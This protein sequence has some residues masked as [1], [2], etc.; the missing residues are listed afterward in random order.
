MI[1]LPEILRGLAALPFDAQSEATGIANLAFP[2][3]AQRL[4]EVDTTI[5]D[6]AR[7]LALKARWI[8]IADAL[9]EMHD[10]RAEMIEDGEWR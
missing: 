7:K 3:N 6:R 10:V 1:D 5:H 8:D 9:D 4:G 2:K